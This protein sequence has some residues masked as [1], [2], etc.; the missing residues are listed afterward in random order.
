MQ[1][2]MC[3]RYLLDILGLSDDVKVID[4]A[5]SNIEGRWAAGEIDAAF[6]W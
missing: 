1:M 5:I 2:C 4:V 3:A 6:V